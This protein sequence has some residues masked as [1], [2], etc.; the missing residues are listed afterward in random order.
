ML[1]ITKAVYDHGFA[2]RNPVNSRAAMRTQH[3][4]R[5]I[6][7]TLEGTKV[8]SLNS[9]HKNYARSIAGT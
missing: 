9:A 3:R 2:S 5:C 7:S 1:K 6:S 4:M 8:K